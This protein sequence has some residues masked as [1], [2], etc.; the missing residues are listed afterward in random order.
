MNFDRTIHTDVKV[1]TPSASYTATQAG[2]N[3]I[4]TIAAESGT[5]FIISAA[6]TSGTFTPVVKDG[7]DSGLSDGAAVDDSFLVGSSLSVAPEA[8][9]AITAANQVKKIGYIGKKRYLTVDLTGAS[10]PS[11]FVGVIIVLQMLKDTINQS[12]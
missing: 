1:I 10:T 4:D 2:V 3:I 8:A 7:N 5:I 6:W 9:A 12:A 11:A